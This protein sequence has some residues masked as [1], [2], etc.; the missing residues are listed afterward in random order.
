MSEHEQCRLNLID[1]ERDRDRDKMV[2]LKAQM[3][4][5]RPSKCCSFADVPSLKS[6]ELL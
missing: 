3:Q 4:T 6:I 5:C 1:R 2:D